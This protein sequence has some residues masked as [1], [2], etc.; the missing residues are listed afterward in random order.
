[1][2]K[3]SPW[4]VAVVATVA[5]AAS[6]SELQRMR[7]RFVEVTRHSFHDHMD[8][9]RFMIRAALADV[10]NPIVVIG[11]SITEMSRLP[12][13]IAGRPV[14]NAGIGGATIE[15]FETIA[16]NLL[17]GS[18]PSLIAIA[19]G[20]NDAGS[21]SIQEEYAKLLRD[22]KKISPRLIAIGTSLQDGSDQ[23]NDQIKAAA[24]NEGIPFLEERL[25]GDSTMSDRI[26]LNAVGYKQWTPKLV[27]AISQ[28]VD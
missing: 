23:I 18:Q 12:D 8:V 24:E 17:I 13:S 21:N 1:M 26:H 25:S 28:N 4:I 19:L 11:D 7:K 5:F 22:L 9:R 16:R 10:K 27:S 15:D 3:I 20:T 6:F 2:R 14:I